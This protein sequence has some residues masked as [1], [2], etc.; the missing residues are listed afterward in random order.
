MQLFYLFHYP[1]YLT[2]HFMWPTPLHNR[3]LQ[4]KHRP[5]QLRGCLYRRT[6]RAF[7]R[8]RRERVPHR[9]LSPTGRQNLH[10]RIGGKRL[11]GRF[12]SGPRRRLRS[13]RKNS[14]ETSSGARGHEVLLSHVPLHGAWERADG[15]S[16]H[17]TL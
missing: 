14:S 13:A 10:V 16:L 15:G 17:A 9:S 12:P 2:W 5:S 4:H 3:Y 7:L 1:L 6:L 8:G 11:R